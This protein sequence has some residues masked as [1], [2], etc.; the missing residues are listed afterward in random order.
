MS[1]NKSSRHIIGES[2]QEFTTLANRFDDITIGGLPWAIRNGIINNEEFTMASVV[3]TLSVAMAFF[4][5][6]QS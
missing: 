3:V 1:K 6:V 2:A 4:A 5:N